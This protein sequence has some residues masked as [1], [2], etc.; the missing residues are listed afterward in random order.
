MWHNET[1]K[2]LVKCY[3]DCGLENIFTY[4]NAQKWVNMSL[5]YL[6]ILSGASEHYKG[7]SVK[8]LLSIRNY[9]TK[10][11]IPIDSYIIDILWKEGINSL[12]LKDGV[13]VD[14]NK[15][16]VVPSEYV[17]GWS[18]WNEDDYVTV[19]KESMK[20]C[21]EV[22]IEWES[23]EWIKRAKERKK[24]RYICTGKSR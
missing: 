17:K 20:I 5:K 11:H 1:C 22:P 21:G 16:Y 8:K 19:K 4:G 3:S 12:P 7:E 23:Y 24:W 13:N 9:T 10:L 18:N 14:R 15:D 6:F 2:D